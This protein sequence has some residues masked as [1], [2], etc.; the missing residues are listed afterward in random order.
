MNDVVN[1]EQNTLSFDDINFEASLDNIKNIPALEGSNRTKMFLPD[2]YTHNFNGE[3]IILSFLV[4]WNEHS[5]LQAINMLDS[6]IKNGIL[7]VKKP[8]YLVPWNTF[9]FLNDSSARFA[10]FDLNGLFTTTK[11][12]DNP[13]SAEE[14]I[15][16]DIQDDFHLISSLHNKDKLFNFD[17]HWASSKVWEDWSGTFSFS[18]PE[19]ASFLEDKSLHLWDAVIKGFPIPDYEKWE[20]WALEEFCHS[21]WVWSA[22]IESLNKDNYLSYL[23]CF[24]LLIFNLSKA[25]FVDIKYYNFI[26]WLLD[27]HKNL[28]GEENSYAPRVWKL[29]FSISNE[30]EKV[31]SSSVDVT[32][33]E[34]IISDLENV[35]SV[36]YLVWDWNPYTFLEVSSW[37]EIIK[38][39]KVNREEVVISTSK[40]GILIMPKSAKWIMEKIKAW[41]NKITI[42]FI[43]E[44][45]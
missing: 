16:L 24:E 33:W 26:E 9:S 41:A 1:L 40:S 11:N 22:T 44:K 8:I 18:Q 13:K 36:E 6:L 3:W 15:A 30:A 14:K 23:A 5:W 17:L 29:L 20:T 27:Y 31:L 21:I 34:I 32:W 42:W 38:L 4:H 12:S 35:S 37:D 2:K 45:K 28:A 19:S 43:W 39:I 10:E 7:E 25:W